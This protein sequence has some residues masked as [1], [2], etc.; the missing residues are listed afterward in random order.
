MGDAPQVRLGKGVHSST[1][2]VIG[3]PFDLCGRKP[4]SRLGPAAV[5]IADLAGAMR[6]IGVEITR[7]E[8]I[9]GPECAAQLPGLKNFDPALECVKKL[10]TRV[11]QALQRG[12]TPLVIGGDH[13][14]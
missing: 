1:V 5:R 2:E 10:R 7:D 3:V 6:S 14:I 12:E 4:G 9:T 13:F 8:D 11:L